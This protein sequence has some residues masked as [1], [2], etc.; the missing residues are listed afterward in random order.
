MK[1]ILIL[2]AFLLAP[3]LAFAQAKTSLCVITSGVNNCINVDAVNPLPISGT[4]S[5]TGGTV[6]NAASGQATT[7]TN[8]GA[9]SWLYGFNGVTWDQLQVDASKFLKV[10]CLAGCAGGTASNASSAFA[11]SST[12]GQALAFLYGFNGTTWDQ[13]RVDG[14]KSLNVNCVTG[15]A[16]GATQNVNIT[17]IG[18]SAPSATN[19]LWVS[20]ATGATF[21]ISGAISG[22]VTA[23]AGTNLNTSALALETGGNLATIATN[24]GRIPAQGQALAAASTPVVLTAAQIT[25]LT[26][27]S[28]VTAN[29][30]TSGSL[31]LEAGGNLASLVS[32]LGAVTASPVA[33][34]V[35]DRLKTINTT[36]ASPF[37][38]GGSIGNT[39]FASTQSGTW[40][41][42]PGNTA[43]TTPWLASINA[44]GNTATV[45]A[46]GAL[47]V[48]GSAA[49][50]PVSG[51][52]TANL[53]TLNGAATA[54]KQPALGTA[55]SPSTDVISIQGVVSG[56]AVPMSAAS[57]PLPTLAATS[58]KQSDGSQKTQIVDGSGNVIASTS[59]NLNVQCANCSGSGVSTADAATFTAG[60]SLFAGSGGFFQ[61]TA[62]SNPLTTGK[63][64]MV[65]MTATRAF[66]V[67][68]RDSS[69]A[70][71]LV[72]T[73]AN[74][75]SQ[76][77]QETAINTV[78]GTQ[79]DTAWVSGSGTA[80]ALLK[81]IAGGIAGSIPAGSAIVGKVGID[82]TTPGTTN[83]VSTAYIGSTA[84][85][86]GS[87]AM[88]S[89]TQRFALA[90]DSPG[91]VTLG[92]TTMS[93]SVP[94]TIAS[95]QSAVPVTS[96]PYP[97][98][99]TA[100]TASATGT[101]AATTAT[102]AGT[103]SK[104]TY[105]CSMSI[106]SNA[107]AAA[108]GNATVTGTITGTLNFTHWTAPLASGIGLTEMIFNPCVP[109]SATNTGIAV[110]SPAPG[111]GGVVSSTATGYQL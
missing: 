59:N 95:N 17:Q 8:Q 70:E 1:R 81:N 7:A 3:N 44:G 65:Q 56:T 83:A 99:A 88:T 39:T 45:S 84:V 50:Q 75:A 73:A 63:Q 101:T 13:L 30:G 55:G 80:I 9:V 72:S 52:V 68:P 98:G 35:L 25:T 23:N 97:T 92:Q 69:G 78:L 110:I 100:I 111:T 57:L 94:V 15:C 22:T 6:S 61:T 76:I 67:N 19:Q 60:T 82:Q 40:T 26:P 89:G 21:P 105:I 102:L 48:D 10:N 85:A 96:G 2:L 37:Q 14:S 106:R 32:Q 4:F 43:N 5:Q 62:T 66:F 33:N 51:T 90:T 31:A 16:A 108:T 109:A 28:T 11:T 53:G 64:G 18:G 93:A 87:G 29:I 47:K 104:T 24:T 49:T 71:I 103:S 54:V 74:Q 20:P 91:I 12:N 79:A 77:T 41:V 27:L 42:Q 38:A 58:T 46:G 34:T 86:T 107:T 36:L